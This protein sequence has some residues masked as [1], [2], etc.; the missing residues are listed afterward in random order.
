MLFAL[1]LYS[2][3]E[4]DSGLRL[5]TAY[6]VPF[7]ARS[8]RHERPRPPDAKHEISHRRRAV[9]QLVSAASLV[10]RQAVG[11][12]GRILS[13]GMWPVATEAKW[14]L[15]ATASLE[16]AGAAR[17]TPTRHVIKPFRRDISCHVRARL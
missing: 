13:R 7:P 16:F 5:G 12:N 11:P 4:N 1:V 10:H 2:W 3:D 6:H 17:A 9:E 15:L 8:H 14:Q